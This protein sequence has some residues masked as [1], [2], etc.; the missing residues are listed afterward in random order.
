MVGA[1]PYLFMSV[2]LGT[3]LPAMADVLHGDAA[4]PWPLACVGLTAGL[5]ASTIISTAAKRKIDEAA[6]AARSPAALPSAPPAKAA[7]HSRSPTRARGLATP[8]SGG[9]RKATPSSG[10][11][12]RRS[13]GK[14]AS[15]RRAARSKAS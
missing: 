4:M 6:H 7:R 9:S 3:F 15:A 2:Y 14:P 5:A 11:S 13:G 12:R 10:G 8:S 1:F